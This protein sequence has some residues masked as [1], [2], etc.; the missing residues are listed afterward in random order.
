LNVSANYGLL[1]RL[2]NIELRRE[3]PTP[4]AAFPH[5]SA[6]ELGRHALTAPRDF[7]VLVVRLSQQFENLLLIKR[8]GMF[9]LQGAAPR[10]ASGR[11]YEDAEEEAGD[12]AAAASTAAP[13]AR[14]RQRMTMSTVGCPPQIHSGRARRTQRPRLGG[15][16]ADRW[17]GAVA[18]RPGAAPHRGSAVGV[19]R[20]TPKRNRGL[21]RPQKSHATGPSSQKFVDTRTHGARRSP[22]RHSPTRMLTLSLAFLT[23]A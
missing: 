18:A 22:H 23:W 9:F 8:F 13:T 10:H 17:W 11:P 4:P 7:R 14:T 20:A 1:L 3:F 12:E 19:A 15:V 16:E 5:G 2:E 6:T 21:S